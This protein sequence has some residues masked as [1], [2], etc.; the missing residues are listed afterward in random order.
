MQANVQNL[1]RHFGVTR[2]VDDVSFSVRSGDVVGFVGPNGAG[3]TTTL[4]IMATLDEPTDGDVFIDDVSVREMPEHVRN[5]IGFVPDALPTHGDITVHEYLDFFGRA[6]GLTGRK[7]QRA[8]D[9]VEDFTGLTALRNKLLKGLSKGMKQ[10]VSVG[11]AL[12][13]DPDLLL[14]D[15]P[16]AGLDPRARVE[17]RELVSVL[18]GMG[19]AV[20]ISSHILTELTEICNGVVIVEKGR[21]LE[22]GSIDE[23]MSRSRERQMIAIRTQDDPDMLVKVLMELPH[24]HTAHQ[25]SREAH[26]ELDGGDEQA[27]ELLAEI[28]RRGHRVIEFRHIRDDLEDIFMKVTKGEVQ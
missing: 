20:L 27:A 9:E 7:R 2:A 19:K 14:M 4:R 15:E 13:H 25:A 3:K 21:I 10:R 17:F 6:Y 28:S 5:R 18:A 11:R 16:A 22:T 8:L 24:V 23:V 1:K 26:V 12:I